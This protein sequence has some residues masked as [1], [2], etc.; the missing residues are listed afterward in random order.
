MYE[1]IPLRLLIKNTHMVY[2]FLMLFL[3][4]SCSVYKTT[5]YSEGDLFPCINIELLDQCWR[6]LHKISNSGTH[7]SLFLSVS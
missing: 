3:L 7:L 4:V 1:C 6:D 2:T 5:H